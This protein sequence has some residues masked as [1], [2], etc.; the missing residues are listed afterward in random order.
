MATFSNAMGS[1]YV[2]LERQ[3][4]QPVQV[5]LCASNPV[6]EAARSGQAS[7][8]HEQGP[9]PRLASLAYIRPS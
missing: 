8:Q 7:S 3:E 5:Q 2:R 1:W 6:Q 4:Q 9:Q